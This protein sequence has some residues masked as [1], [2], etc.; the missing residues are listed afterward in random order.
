MQLDK[1][2]VSGTPLAGISL[3]PLLH[4]RPLHSLTKLEINGCGSARRN[5]EVLAGSPFWTQAT[6]L[7][8]HSGT[9][10]AS[11]F[12]PLCQSAGPPALRVTAGPAVPGWRPAAEFAAGYQLG[13]KRYA[14][15]VDEPATGL[16][17]LDAATV[18]ALKAALRG[19]G[20]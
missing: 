16:P 15:R 12:E 19:E 6:E 8:A 20:K 13:R 4:S 5:M 3:E 14:C 10:P 9:I 11:T 7:R 17:P 18:D 1:L 2:D